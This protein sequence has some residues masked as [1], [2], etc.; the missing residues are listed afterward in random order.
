MFCIIN[1]ISGMSWDFMVHVSAAVGRIFDDK[2]CLL[3]I[4]AI[5]VNCRISPEMPQIETP[6]LSQGKVI[7]QALLQGVLI[8]VTNPSLADM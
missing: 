1:L 5:F 4:L 7:V 6:D 3:E 2:K 8:T